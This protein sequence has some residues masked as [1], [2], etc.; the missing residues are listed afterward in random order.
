MTGWAGGG[1][2]QAGGPLDYQT[3][4]LAGGAGVFGFITAH[5]TGTGPMIMAH[6]RELPA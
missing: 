1:L 6:S 2:W 5:P 3:G 4:C